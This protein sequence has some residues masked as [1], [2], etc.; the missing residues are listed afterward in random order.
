MK[1]INKISLFILVPLLL[2][3]VGC[4]KFLAVTPKTSVADEAL[5][6]NETGFQQA[7]TGV[8]VSL[9]SQNLYGDNLTMSYLSALAKNYNITSIE[10]SG[11]YL[12]N[13]FN[14]QNATQ[15]SSIWSEAYTAIATLNNI[16]SHIDSKKSVFSGDNY[17]LIKGEVLGLRAYLHFDLLRLYGK[18]Y[19]TSADSK[20][21]PYRTEFNLA[22][23]VPNTHKE[24][25]AQALKD[26]DEA[27][28]LLQ[29]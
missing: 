12:T 21:I 22:N 26:L 15:V 10:T 13:T 24:V 28:T 27:E 2:M 18:N 7:L 1:T 5:F 11:L 9:A 4:K 19:S 20:S 25:V 16:L 6:G 23:K 17:S 14:Y 8:Y 3:F 29:K